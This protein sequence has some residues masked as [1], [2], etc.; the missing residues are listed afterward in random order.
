M[1]QDHLTPPIIHISKSSYEDW[2]SLFDADEER[3]NSCDKSQTKVGQTDEHTGL[4]TLFDV[5]M[6][7]MGKRLSSPEFQAMIESYVDHHDVYTFEPLAPP[8]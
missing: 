2:K 3:A 6:G 5:D 4:I 8:A 7:A 1:V